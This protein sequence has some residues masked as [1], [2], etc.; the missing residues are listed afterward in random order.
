MQISIAIRGST[1]LTC[2]ATAG[3]PVI[4][5][6]AGAVLI[7][8]SQVGAFQVWN[9]SPPPAHNHTLTVSPE[10]V[11]ATEAWLEINSKLKSL[12]PP[13]QNGADPLGVTRARLQSALA[14]AAATVAATGDGT[15]V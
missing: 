1:C 6:P 15:Y 2:L 10:A 4:P 13:P 7:D 8:D 9:A 5:Q 14:A 3:I 12:D 11:A